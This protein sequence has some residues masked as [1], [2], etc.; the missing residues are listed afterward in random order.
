MIVKN[1]EKYLR[2]CLTSVFGI[3]DDIVI[4][5]TGSTDNTIE[6]AKEFGARIFHFPWI[7]DFAAARNFA[8]D[9]TDKGWILY[10][11]ADEKLSPSSVKELNKIT[12]SFPSKAYLC[13][14]ISIAEKDTPSTVMMY[15]R[16]F[17][18]RKAVR[19]VGKVHEQIEDSIHR[20]KIP[21][22]VS[23][24]NITHIGYNIPKEELKLKAE[25]NLQLLFEEYKTNPSGYISF[26]IA[27]TYGVLNDPKSEKYFGE[28][29]EKGLDRNEY[30]SIAY[31][32]MAIKNAERTNIKKAE[33]LILL[34]LLAD[35]NQPLTLI[36]AANI[37]LILK[38][39]GKASE[40]IL[41]AYNI[42]LKISEGKGSSFQTAYLDNDS[43]CI[44]GLHIAIGADNKELFRFFFTKLKENNHIVFNLFN[45][46][47]NNIYIDPETIE[48]SIQ[49]LTEKYL[50]ALIAALKNYCFT[51]SKINLLT[52]LSVKFPH[53]PKVLI[54]FGIVLSESGKL[55]ECI[56]I[57]ESAL[58]NDPD[59]PALVFYL[60]SA[61]L[62]TND[63]GPVNKLV[64]NAEKK[65]SAL[66]AVISRLELVKQKL[67][68]I[69]G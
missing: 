34:S 68:L 47:I 51:E 43:I 63:I 44:Y 42:N 67:F 6:I 26:Q 21:L 69:T 14:V 7:N 10:L 18:A 57:F 50:D 37:Y 11:D 4:V 28:A 32:F 36:G 25:R 1:E 59:N 29:I 48:I 38:N 8:L 56:N 27:Q 58:I 2:D 45:L 53:N 5:D 22:L 12:S 41:K 46:I 54:L 33:E 66:P 24:V 13:N 30:K 9:Q 55:K 17:P 31:R 65:F 61:Y 52:V 23:K 3:V 40:Y 35:K 19:F 60:I 49:S 64:L 20:N 16:L 39:Y 62:K 15:P